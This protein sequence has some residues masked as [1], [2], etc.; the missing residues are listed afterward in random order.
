MLYYGENCQ[1]TSLFTTTGF[2]FLLLMSAFTIRLAINTLSSKLPSSKNPKRVKRGRRKR[3]KCFRQ[4]LLAVRGVV[5]HAYCAGNAIK[6][7]NASIS[8]LFCVIIALLS[9]LTFC[10]SNFL[11]TL[12]HQTE[13][14]L[15]SFVSPVSFSILAP[16]SVAAM[17]NVSFVWFEFAN[18]AVLNITS[19]RNMKKQSKRVLGTLCFFYFVAISIIYGWTGDYSW[20][21]V[22]TVIYTICVGFVFLKGAF[23]I[24]R[25]LQVKVFPNMS[26]SVGFSRISS[27]FVKQT[28]QQSRKIKNA[29]AKKITNRNLSNQTAN[30]DEYKGQ[31]EEQSKKIDQTTHNIKIISCASTAE[32][33]NMGKHDQSMKNLGIND[34]NDSSTQ[35]FVGPALCWGNVRVFFSFGSRPKKAYERILKISDS[36]NTVKKVLLFSFALA[37]HCVL[38]CIALM[39]YFLFNT[40]VTRYYQLLSALLVIADL[41]FIHLWIIHYLAG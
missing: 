33:E 18:T 6:R 14:V 28:E 27:A 40:P 15:A 17:L 26:H 23:M 11:R 8:T 12:N 38:F 5:L 2:G 24:S 3:K 41:L 7:Q 32:N 16:F 22:L 21:A 10:F 37:F 19:Q 29:W 25:K 39:C 4:C 9:I 20:I 35:N 34:S 13:R 30:D 31:L 36:N 1:H